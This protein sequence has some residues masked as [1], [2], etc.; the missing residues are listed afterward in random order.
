MTAGSGLRWIVT[1]L[2]LFGCESVAFGQGTRDPSNPIPPFVTY[3][4][5][6]SNTTPPTPNVYSNIYGPSVGAVGRV[7]RLRRA[8][9]VRRNH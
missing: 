7:P 6:P 8:D 4:Q 9:P 1:A 3:Q 2:A 5:L